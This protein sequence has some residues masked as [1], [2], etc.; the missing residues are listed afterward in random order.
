MKYYIIRTKERYMLNLNGDVIGC[1]PPKFICIVEKEE[2][3]KDFCVKNSDY[4]TYEK[5][6]TKQ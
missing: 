3:A 1:E 4:Y 2:V 5:V 6:E